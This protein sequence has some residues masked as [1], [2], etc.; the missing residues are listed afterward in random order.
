MPLYAGFDGTPL[1]Y[2]DSSPDHGGHAPPVIALAGG[3]ARHPSYLGDFAG[4]GSRF[5]LIIPHLR[6]VG[7]S[8]APSRAELGSFWRQAEDL[9]RLREH[10]GLDRAVLVGH[11]A[12][13]RL[14]I[15]YAARFP[16]RIAGI[17][18][19][20]PPA[21]YLVDTPSD[22]DELIARHRGEPAFAAAVQASEAG[23]DLIDDDA[24]NAWQLRVTPMGY[25]V[26]GSAE[27]AHSVIG[28]WNLAA[29]KA[30]FSVEPPAD[31]VARIGR[32]AAPVLVIAGAEDCLTGVAPVKA[33][34]ARFPAGRL[35]L[36]ERCGHYP[37]VEQPSAFRRAIDAF[38]DEREHAG[39]PVGPTFEP[40]HLPKDP[41]LP[42][43]GRLPSPPTT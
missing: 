11:S 15:A 18:L 12:G 27:Q 26:W 5:R 23:P 30:Y 28:R 2:A 9:D 10:L 31:L 17:V 8:P 36:I 22:T 25:A 35:E 42:R 37:W 7:H 4:L 43:S 16:D 14:A 6:G 21:G 41:Q 32:V 24:F 1:H 20:T 39:K 33:L 19:I 29:V 13:T 3:A 40:R 34:A 38:L